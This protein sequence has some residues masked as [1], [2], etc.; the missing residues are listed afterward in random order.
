MKAGM[1]KTH[2]VLHPNE[3]IR[4]PRMLLLFASPDRWRGQN[5]L[6]Q[7]IL[8][9]HRPML[10][11][12]PL[13]APITWGN[14]GGTTAEVHLD[15]IQNI[16]KHKLPIDYYWIDAGW[17]GKL[18]V[19]D[20]AGNVGW[21]EVK[22]DLYPNG[23]K[24]LSDLLKKS[25]RELMVWFEP[26]RVMKGTPWANEHPDWMFHLGDN[27]TLLTNLGNPDACKFV[28]D[29]ISKM[30]DDFGLGCYR[31][32]FNMDPLPYWQAND[33]ENRQ[34]INEIRDTEGLYAF[35][36]G[37][38]Q[39]H[40][41]LM[42]DNCASG[43]RRID[44]ET[45]GRATPFWRT[46]GPRDAIAHQCHSYGLMGWVPLSAISEDREGDTYEFRSSMCSGL[47]INWFHSGDGPQ[48]KMPADAPFAWGKKILDEYLTLRDFY[49]GDYYPLTPYTQD[50]SA[51]MGW[52]FD[53]PEKGDGMVQM[54]RRPDSLY[55]SIR[56][57]LRGIDPDA[58][59]SV[60]NIDEPGSKDI[61]GR[62]LAENGLLI[63]IKDKPGAV[64]ITYKKKS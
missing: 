31:Q 4:T 53:R 61:S 33:A 15:N 39:R 16:I 34:G 24:P 5:L 58:T 1:A 45:T 30:I 60:T 48:K 13:V 59:Y 37:L 57:Q 27:P 6:R 7:F 17:Y 2:L 64:V 54:F 43:G 50:R 47:C 9:Y 41:N 56:V 44:L 51:W 49:Y 28:T 26:E 8:T 40:P 23:M 18:G 32:D 55:E 42:I 12:K 3:T 25:G 21:W 20:W 35:W 62:E 63:V 52:Q 19:E 10:N 36:D 22:K 11:G 38:L 14:W 29:A 46:D